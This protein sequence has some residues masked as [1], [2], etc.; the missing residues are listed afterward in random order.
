[1]DV[2]DAEYQCHKQNTSSQAKSCVN[3]ASF[4]FMANFENFFLRWGIT[5]AKN[6]WTYIIASVVI[7]ATCSIGLLN[8]TAENRPTKLWIPQDSGF[9]HNSEWLQEH[10]PNEIRIQSWVLVD[11][12]V[13]RPATFLWMLELHDNISE[14]AS[15]NGYKWKDVCF[16][17]PVVTEPET[18]RRRKRQANS[19]EIESFGFD[20]FDFDGFDSN[21]EDISAPAL[22]PNF[23]PAIDLPIGI[24]CDIVE[25]LEEAC[26]ENNI[27]DIWNYKKEVISKLSRQDIINAINSVE[28]SNLTRVQYS[29][30]IGQPRYNESGHIV[31]AGSVLVQLLTRVNYSLITNDATSNDAG[32]GDLVDPISLEWEG[33]FVNLLHNFTVT[34]NNSNLFYMASRS[35]GD[36]SSATIL[37][38]V[39]LLS[40][41]ICVVF[42][43]VQLMLGKFNLVEQRAFLSLTGIA[44]VAMAILVSYGL[45]SAF[46]VFYGPVH[47]IL[48]FLLLGIG[49]DDMFVI[50]QCW[51]NLS[52][53]EMKR[54]LPVRIGITMKHAGV[55]ITITSVTDFAAF[56]VG[57]TTVLPSLRSFCIY[58]AV[59]ILATYLFQASFFVAWLT[60]DQRRIE[61]H[62]DGMLPCFVHRNWKPSTL[63]RIEPL[64][65]FFSR[66]L[67]KYLFK[68]PAKVFILIVS[69]FLLGVNTWGSVLMRQEFNPLWFIPT[70]TYLSQYFST[71]E[72]HYPDNGQLASIY[73]QTKNLSSNLD[74]LEALIDTVRNET[75]IVSQVDDWF[76]GFKDFTAKRHAIDWSSQNMTDEQFS[77]YL[78]NYLFTQKGAKFRSNFKFEKSLECRSSIAPPI[79]ITNFDFVFRPFSGREEHIPAMRRIK[80]IAEEYSLE[81]GSHVF[82]SARIFS[83]WETDEVIME[84]LYRNLAIAMVCV[85]VTTFILIANLFA[86]LLVLLCVVLTLICVNGSM[87]FWGLTIDTVS[88]INLVLAIGLCVDYAAHVAHTFMTKTGTRNERAAATISSI[89]PAVFHGGFSTFLAFIF[90]ANS[91]SHVFL[92][93]FKIFVLVVAYGLFHGLL[94]FPVVLSL[95]GPAPFD[96]AAPPDVED[97]AVTAE[98]LEPQLSHREKKTLEHRSNTKPLLLSSSLFHNNND[99]NT[100]SVWNLA[101]YTNRA[102]DHRDHISSAPTLLAITIFVGFTLAG[103]LLLWRR[104]RYA[105]REVIC[106]YT[107]LN[108]EVTLSANDILSSEANEDHEFHLDMS[109]DTPT[110]SSDDEELLRSQQVRGMATLKMISIRLKSVK[111]IQ[112]ITQSMKM[113]SAAKYTKA[114]RELK[115]AR[116]Y[117][118]GAQEF[119]KKAEVKDEEGDKGQLIIAVSS[120]RGLC[121]AV[122]SSIGRIVKADIAANPNTKVVIVGD[123]VRNILQRLYGNNIAMVV[124][125]V[126]RKP[127][128]FGDAAIIAQSIINSGLEFS[129]GKILFNAFR[130]VV[131]FRTTEMPLYSQTAVANASK[132]PVYDSLDSD[133]IQSYTEF[134]LAS[135][136]FYS[137]KENATSEQSSR[138]TSMDNASKNA[139]EMIDKLTMT[140]NR[141]RQAVITREL[142]EIISGAAALET[143]N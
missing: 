119:Y 38:D 79:S 57:A 49:I 120:D 100:S 40:A 35:F 140:F 94:F 80:E 86:C 62:R 73:I 109:D 30:L 123:K 132:L 125:E 110:S 15:T 81:F 141:T 31:G 104:Y 107:T 101:H 7:A 27:L 28:R 59:G 88:C 19:S 126:G 129:K 53:E 1:M 14:L 135:L 11:D 93:F 13:L 75:L 52:K 51:S 74:Q 96:V 9:V 69:A 97:K 138:M 67:A 91:D 61:S 64:Q 63:S 58:S 82:A 37:G 34:L 68:W 92:T 131:S 32:T 5:V 26:L 124:T 16:K 133:V 4:V 102:V 98:E 117:G 90:L 41:G 87:H 128:V 12:D 43:Y 111:N 25:G 50:V 103:L 105:N 44:S 36:I 95:V 99:T 39:R 72:S 6:P 143:K 65:V 20:D 17:V 113:V 42:I 46:G 29:N 76:T 134:S 21:F 71:I 137:M 78:K 142:I 22:D 18:K 85:F 10:F 23:E 116:P 77:T 66:I 8:F 3:R 130:T 112:K 121:G 139:G 115:L 118:I 106:H 45:C 108:Q 60:L 47:S 33:A 56:A 54:S 136:L 55:S 89:G 83:S 84:E 127:A 70:S 24:F 122:H 114:E 2:T 48:P